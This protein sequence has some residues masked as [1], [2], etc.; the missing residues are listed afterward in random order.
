M[1]TGKSIKIALAI[2][3]KTPQWLADELEVTKQAVSH[4]INNTAMSGTNINKVAKTLG[5]KSSE[6]IALGED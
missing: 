1:N 5:Y 2:R 3:E 6:F 4:L